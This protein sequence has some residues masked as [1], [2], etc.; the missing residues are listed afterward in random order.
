MTETGTGPQR[1]LVVAAHPDDEI[2]GCGGTVAR[3]CAAGDQVDILIVAEGATA[4]AV[5][6][7]RTLNNSAVAALRNSAERS[8]E[9]LGASVP[10]FGGLPDNR[11]DQTDLL[12]VTTL[13]EQKV[14]ANVPAI[15]YTHHGGDLNVDHRI[16]HQAV[17]TACRPLPESTVTAIYGFETPSSTE[18]AG[19]SLPSFEPNKFV[20]ISETLDKKLAALAQYESEMRTFPHPRSVEAITA[21]AQWRGACCGVVAAEAFMVIREVVRR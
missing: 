21:L 7:N 6:R 18:W 16:V 4:R 11:L 10:T 2:L 14:R 20:E 19:G 13:V 15:V 9:V 3:H 1:I 12:E 17:V 5:A 8:A